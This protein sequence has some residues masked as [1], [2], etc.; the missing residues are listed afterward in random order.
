MSGTERD[1]PQLRNLRPAW[2]KGVSGNPNGRPRIEPRV[3]RH[4]RKYD[5]KMCRM[6]AEIAQDKT[7]PPSERRRAAM[8]LIAV[9]SG[10]P[11]L[12]Q[13][14]AG[15][16][17][18][19]LTPLVNI[20]L[21][22]NSGASLSP[23][24]AYH[25]MISGEL[26]LDPRHPAF[27]SR[28]PLEGRVEA[29]PAAAAPGAANPPREEGQAPGSEYAA[30]APSGAAELPARAAEDPEFRPLEPPTQAEPPPAPGLM[31][32]ALC[33]SFTP[34]PSA[35]PIDPAEVGRIKARLRS[36]RE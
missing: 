35:K 17:G 18:E 9:G 8:D 23:E 33:G 10:R 15:R 1:S 25:M 19:S 26:P 36:M 13:E 27:A 4:A 14:I 34:D 3:R 28:Q 24:Q 32:P 6:L 7:V 20:D 21:R 12:V 11:A 22:N 31:R 2:P 29:A 16:G 5:R 30:P